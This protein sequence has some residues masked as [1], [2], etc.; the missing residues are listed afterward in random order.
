MI[1][2]P[3]GT[4]TFLFTDIEGSTRLH[5]ARPEAYRAALARH[6]AILDRAVA[7]HGGVVFQR[8]GDSF[9]VAF[10]NPSAAVH[11]AF[12]AQQA[13]QREPWGELG[14]LRVRMG[15]HTGEVHIQDDQ[16]VGLALHR[17]A[18]LMSSAHGGQTIL[19][20]VTASLVR[21]SL[22]PET[23]L[24]DLGEHRLRDLAEPE[25]IYQLVAPG[26]PDAHPPL[27]TLTASPNNLPLQMTPFIGREQQ[28]QAVRTALLHPDT[29]LLTLTGPGGTGK[30]RLSLQV[31]ADLLESF[32]DGV[33]FV[34]L[35]P[36]TNPDLVL[37][38]IAQPLD[39]RDTS[40][41]P[42]LDSLKDFLAPRQLLLILDNFEQVID[43]ATSVAELLASAPGLRMLITSRSALRLY[44]EREYP[45]PPLALPDYRTAPSAAHLAQF[46]AVCLFVDRAQ[47]A[48]PDFGLT[49][50]NAA[51]VAE[52][53][54][55]LDGLPLAIELAAARTRSLPPRAMLQRMDR[56]LPL[57]T[58]GA[59]DLP[60]RQQT[61]RGAIA[62]SYDLLEPAEQML[63]RRLAVFRGCTLEAAETVCAG[64]PPRPGTASVAL[65]LLDTDVLDGL[66]S[67]VDKNLIRQDEGVDGQ[68]W[69]VMLETI[70]EYALERLE[71]SGEAQ[72]LQRRLILAATQLAESAEYELYGPRQS[73][74]FARLEQEH[75]NARSSLSWCEEHGYAQP[76]FRLVIALW[77]FW[78]ARGHLREGRE[79]LASVLRRFPATAESRH[80][81]LRAK[82]LQAAGTLAAIQNDFAAAR[83]LHEEQ[84]ALSQAMQD[85]VG[86]FSALHNL[87]TA[88][89]QQG[90]HA[91]AREYLDASVTIARELG[92]QHLAAALHH[93]G[94]VVSELGDF[95][96]ARA[97]FEE[98]LSVSRDISVPPTSLA[99][100]LLTYAVALLEQRHLDEAE[101]HAA[102]ALEL[103]HQVGDRRSMALALTQLGT[104]ALARGDRETARERLCTSISIL[105]E[106]GDVAAV[107][108]VLERFVV[109]ASASGQP[110]EAIRLA[111]A[112]DAIRAF[113]STPLSLAGQAKLNQTLEPLRRALGSEAT[114]EAWR[115]GQT[116]NLEAAVAAALR[117][118]EPMPPS[119][120][121][122]DVS[123]TA[124][125]APSALTRREQEVAV[126][127]AR[128]LT[129]RQIAEQL[130]ITEGT[131]A[132]HV[133]HI[134]NKLGYSSR[135]QVAAWAIETGLVTRSAPP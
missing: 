108:L 77:W 101:G 67:L 71:E 99:Q 123:A 74:W 22:S 27:H 6:D 120:E 114:E 111:G 73:S 61:L 70:R 7:E 110:T 60:A 11:A 38:A 43:A 1:A 93:F 25:R 21:G 125:S 44:G 81:R 57:L 72:T 116:L 126:L 51:A 34:P 39:V 24:K 54:H 5:E 85:R 83:A 23:S 14:E 3:T 46:E 33:Y 10:A 31:A 62:W 13:L 65:P 16:Y 102:E 109:L 130:V 4:V 75:D 117:I 36:I 115:S 98:A 88:A 68:P 35:A 124:A 8:A 59:R 19:S 82:V 104:I 76:A 15:L 9:S 55:R 56:R 12:D 37:S 94:V 96:L 129:N 84:L 52:V 47:A 48:R 66:E 107:A 69:Y 112:A 79:R 118:A 32:S 41:R 78:S 29:R 132:S 49:A 119:A 18:R 100:T 42:L 95:T 53:C 121:P 89:G 131:A 28:I 105:R 2:L 122:A 63:F 87:G 106:L 103:C 40:S 127:I 50:E 30:T 91:A 97:Y 128:G 90:D 64:E 86:E 17:C 58:G 80:A 45:V 135:A 133:V 26:L 113:A 92:G 134:L 20:A